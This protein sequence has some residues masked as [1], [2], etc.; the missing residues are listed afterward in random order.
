LR[1]LSQAYACADAGETFVR[2][3]IKARVKVMNA[4]RFD[5]TV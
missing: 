3:L 4:V 5:L 1:S 2:A